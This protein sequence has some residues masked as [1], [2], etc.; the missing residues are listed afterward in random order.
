MTGRA[1]TGCLFALTLLSACK[2]KATA[3]HGAPGSSAVASAN[4]SAVPAALSTMQVDHGELDTQA[5]QDAAM[6]AATQIATIVYARPHKESRRLGYVRLGAVVKRDPEA[7]KDKV[8]DC[9]GEWYHIYPMGYVCTEDA[10]TD[11]EA[12]LVKA[13]K[14]RAHLDKPMPYAYGF[15]R[16]TAPQY[17]KVPSKKQQIDSEFGLE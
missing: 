10:T 15:V 12:P 2:D 9:K 3:E 14:R 13:T 7:T 4:A 8:G 6:I 17:L 1:I 11:L 5:P 16:A